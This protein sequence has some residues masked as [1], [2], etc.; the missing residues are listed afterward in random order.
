MRLVV[1]SP[2]PV[3]V[4]RFLRIKITWRLPSLIDKILAEAQI[5][6]IAS[7]TIELHESKLDL[8]MTAISSSLSPFCA[9]YRIDIIGVPTYYI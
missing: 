9:K 3:M 6:C 4:G 5:A 7:E 8:F 1:F 2:Q